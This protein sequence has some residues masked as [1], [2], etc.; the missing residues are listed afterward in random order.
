MAA[1]E[2]PIELEQGG[3]DLMEFKFVKDGSSL[4]ISEVRFVGVIKNS[5]YDTEGFPMRFV[6]VDD[7]TVHAYI[8]ADV[9][10]SMDFTKG[11][12]EIKMIQRDG[13]NTPLLKGPVTISLGATDE[14]NYI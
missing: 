10:E 13:F 11:V 9:S 12:Y 4:D 14:T 5:I 8:D 6:H 2:M 1:A 7:Y 3:T